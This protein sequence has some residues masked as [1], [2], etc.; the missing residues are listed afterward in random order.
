MKIE[1]TPKGVCCKKIK[2]E[3]E[4]NIINS[5]DFSGGCSGNLSAISQLVKGMHVNDVI[6]KLENIKCGTKETSC[7]AQLAICLMEYAKQK[8]PQKVTNK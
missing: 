5:T 3:I 7:P 1:Y 8:E 6:N 4:N 2:I